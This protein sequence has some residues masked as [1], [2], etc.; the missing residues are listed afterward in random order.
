MR[1]KRI[2]ENDKTKIETVIRELDE[3]K[4]EALKQAWEQVNRD[5]GSIFGTLLPGTSAK[6]QPPEG[7]SVLDG[8]EVRPGR[9][10]GGGGGRERRGGE[11]RCGG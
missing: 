3:K 1:K 8:L 7:A 2:V 9:S 4:N 10:G 11:S 6:L 5:F